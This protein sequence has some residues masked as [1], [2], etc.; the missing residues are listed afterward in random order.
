MSNTNYDE[1]SILR[2]QDGN[3]IP[4]Y[5]DTVN[6]VFEPLTEGAVF[7]AADANRPVAGEY[8]GQVYFSI[9]TQSIWIW[10]ETDWVVVV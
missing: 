1:T 10:D 7:G 4:Q 2:D 3:P 5:Y 6:S 9:E 8:M